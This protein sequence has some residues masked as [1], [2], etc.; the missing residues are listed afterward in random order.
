MQET[1]GDLQ[2][3]NRLVCG[4]AVLPAEQPPSIP[5]S[6]LLRFLAA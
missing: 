1:S 6:W 5:T 3:V 2:T 4:P